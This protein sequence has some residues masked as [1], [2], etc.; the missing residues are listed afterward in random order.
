MIAKIRDEGLNRSQVMDHISWL[1]DVYGPRLTGG[2]GIRQAADWTLKKFAE[3]G[4][5][6]AHR[7]TFPFGKGWSLVRFSAH[8]VEPQV[9]PLIGFPGSWTPGT[10]GTGHGRCRAGRRSRTRRTSR[11]TAA[12]LKGKIVLTQPAR[13]VRMLEG[14]FVLRMTDKDFEEAATVAGAAGAA[15]AAADAAGRARRSRAACSRRFR[16]LQGRR[17]RRALQPR[18]RQRHVRRAAATCPGGSS[19]PT[20][21]RSSRPAAAR[22][23]PTPAPGCRR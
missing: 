12:R 5:A 8:L 10:N 21:A 9:E 7:E 15:R 22:A 13:A 4:L 16:V 11:S 14:P 6:N 18:Q 1:S 2:P 20:A 3:W 17:C 19:G 23:A